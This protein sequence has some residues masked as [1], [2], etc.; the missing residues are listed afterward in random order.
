MKTKVNQIETLTAY[1]STHMEI[2]E[3]KYIF[4]N[5]VDLGTRI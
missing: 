2:S 1:R 3:K 5:T 4:L